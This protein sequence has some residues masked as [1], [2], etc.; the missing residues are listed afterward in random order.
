MRTHAYFQLV[1][2]EAYQTFVFVCLF[3]WEKNLWQEI[4]RSTESQGE[5]IKITLLDSYYIRLWQ[6]MHRHTAGGTGKKEVLKHDLYIVVVDW[7][8]AI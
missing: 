4:L 6:C 5:L 7:H 1:F 3:F 8:L 2:N